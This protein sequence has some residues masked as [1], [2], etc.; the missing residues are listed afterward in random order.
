MNAHVLEMIN[1]FYR[2][3]SK[4][5]THH[6][7]KISISISKPVWQKSKNWICFCNPNFINNTITTCFL[8]TILNQWEETY[9]CNPITKFTPLIFNDWKQFTAWFDT[10]EGPYLSKS[11]VISFTFVKYATF[12][13][14]WIKNLIPVT[15]CLCQYYVF[16]YCHHDYL[17]NDL[18]LIYLLLALADQYVIKNLI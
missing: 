8:F 3:Q 9:R 11:S 10:Y 15:L 1:S 18:L 6:S 5:Q 4:H 2:S 13:Q 7:E 12:S 16:K 17:Y 14:P